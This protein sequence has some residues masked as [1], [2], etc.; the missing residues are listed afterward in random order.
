MFHV[1]CSG[2]DGIGFYWRFCAAFFVAFSPSLEEMLES[3]PVAHNTRFH[4]IAFS[5]PQRLSILL[6]WLTAGL[7]EEIWFGG[8]GQC[9][10]LRRERLQPTSV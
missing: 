10:A 7:S 8:A 6:G 5:K 1:L 4:T 9:L 3:P 2:L